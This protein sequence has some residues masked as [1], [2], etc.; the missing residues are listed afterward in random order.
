MNKAMDPASVARIVIVVL[1]SFMVFFSLFHM[2]NFSNSRM[3]RQTKDIEQ[4]IRRALVQCYALE[5]SYPAEV[6]YVK[7]YGVSFNRDI[8]IY[9]YEWFGGNLMPE[10]KVFKK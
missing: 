5:G 8:Y 3:E 2:V 1:L 9:Y 7:K 4:I 6:D 10:V